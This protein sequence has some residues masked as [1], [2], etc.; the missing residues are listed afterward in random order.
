MNASVRI[1]R[2]CRITSVALKRKGLAQAAFDERAAANMLMG[3]IFADAMGRDTTPERYPYAMRDAVERYVHL[4]L[5]AV[6]AQ[7][8]VAAAPAGSG[9]A[10]RAASKTSK[11]NER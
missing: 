6:G 5:A 9:A 11:T 3:A 7:A 2:S 8:A 1:S 10:A 4:L